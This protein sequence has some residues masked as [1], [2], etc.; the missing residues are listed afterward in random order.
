MK[1][2]IALITWPHST[3]FQCFFYIMLVCSWYEV[4]SLLYVQSTFYSH[5]VVCSSDMLHPQYACWF[6]PLKYF[7]LRSKMTCTLLHCVLLVLDPI[8]LS[9]GPGSRL[10]RLASAGGF[11]GRVGFWLEWRCWCVIHSC[12]QLTIKHQ[13]TVNFKIVCS[14]LVTLNSWWSTCALALCRMKHGNVLLC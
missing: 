1:K 10:E 13:C 3:S 7:Q 4:Y 8:S 12:E 9:W 6:K 5:H 14:W 2:C 11:F